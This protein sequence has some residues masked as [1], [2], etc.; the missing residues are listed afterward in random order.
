MTTI[1]IGFGDAARSLRIPDWWSAFQFEGRIYE[2][3]ADGSFAFVRRVGAKV[4][5]EEKHEFAVKRSLTS[6]GESWRMD[7]N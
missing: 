2:R 7:G 5:R 6:G 3:R 4:T 1:T